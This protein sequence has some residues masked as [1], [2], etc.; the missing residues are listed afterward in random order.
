MNLHRA[1]K[2]MS[3]RSVYGLLQATILNVTMIRYLLYMFHSNATHGTG[4]CHC[5][6]PGMYLRGTHGSNL[7]RITSNLIEVFR[8]N[9]SVSPE[10]CRDT[11]LK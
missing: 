2:N 3:R 6:A 1:E 5:N 11:I 9:S 4:L 10:E 8:G 7:S